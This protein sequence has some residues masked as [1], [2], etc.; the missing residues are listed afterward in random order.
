MVLECG[1]KRSDRSHTVC[2]LQ[3]SLYHSRFLN[4]LAEST[5][6]VNNCIFIESMCTYHNEFEGLLV[7]MSKLMKILC[8]PQQRT[9]LSA[10]SVG[11]A[12]ATIQSEAMD[13][14]LGGQFYFFFLL[15]AVEP[16][17]ATPPP[18]FFFLAGPNPRLR[19]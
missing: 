4:D 1:G 14:L 19:N 11:I 17:A 16:A 12:A 15:G 6:C 3:P 7:P 9:T 8:S 10:V 13:L 18:F 5:Y 2:P